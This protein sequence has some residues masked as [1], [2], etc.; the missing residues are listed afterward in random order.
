[1]AETNTTNDAEAVLSSVRRIVASGPRGE[2]PS[3]AS[4]DSELETDK[5]L[6]TPSLRVDGPKTS[7]DAPT[8]FHSP[9]RYSTLEHR[10]A[11]LERAV[12]SDGDSWEP[13]GSETTDEETPKSFVFAH[14]PRE[15]TGDYEEDLENLVDEDTLV[16]GASQST[17]SPEER[18]SAMLNGDLEPPAPMD[19]RPS[20]H[21]PIMNDD[22]MHEADID[23]EALREL[24]SHLVR[25]ELQG[26][27]GEKIT[28][29]VRKLVRREIH[30]VLLTHDFG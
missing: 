17:P 14:E 22:G 1:M 18:V 4:V 20:R 29:N 8:F 28:R 2:R 6:L 3:N 27:L 21:A 12:S 15:T 25:A 9:R 24:I 11:E 5:L 7:R 16:L 30:R 13:D 10:I 19:A 26:E 23:D